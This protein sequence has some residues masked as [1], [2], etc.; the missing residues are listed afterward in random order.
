MMNI[1]ASSTLCSTLWKSF[2]AKYY[3]FGYSKLK[4]SQH[5]KDF[6]DKFVRKGRLIYLIT[7]NI[8]LFRNTQNM[9]IL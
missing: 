2:C 3:I 4:D 1:N 7:K 5:L 8:D 6:N 9:D